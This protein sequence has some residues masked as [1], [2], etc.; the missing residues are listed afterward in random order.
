MNKS[1]HEYLNVSRSSSQSRRPQQ[2]DRSQLA[3]CA[4]TVQ[5]YSLEFKDLSKDL[6]TFQRKISKYKENIEIFKKLTQTREIEIEKVQT[7]ISVLQKQTEKVKQ[8]NEKI[9]HSTDEILEEKQQILKEIKSNP[10]LGS[11][12]S[13]IIQEKLK[14][15]KKIIKKLELVNEKMRK[16]IMVEQKLR[17]EAKN[18]SRVSKKKIKALQE[19]ILRCKTSAVEIWAKLENIKINN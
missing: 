1:F 19:Q 8:A 9:I 14:I 6:K 16:Q 2:T 3:D 13:S 10:N 7:N 18:D 17:E 15:E 5:K 12:V 4:D 11:D